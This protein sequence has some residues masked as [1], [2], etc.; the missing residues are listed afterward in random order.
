[1]LRERSQKRQSRE[2]SEEPDGR[3]QKQQRVHWKP[4]IIESD[5]KSD[6]LRTERFA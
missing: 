4:I 1:M 5:D 6:E 2:S 3:S